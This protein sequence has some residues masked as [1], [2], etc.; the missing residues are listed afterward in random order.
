MTEDRMGLLIQEIISI[1]TSPD[2]PNTAAFNEIA[3]S[4]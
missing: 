3:K 4:L 1:I 2:G